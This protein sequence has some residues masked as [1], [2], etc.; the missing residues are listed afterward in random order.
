MSSVAK[1]N[2]TSQGLF[3]PPASV[4][5]LE[6]YP[7]I[8]GTI[9]AILQFWRIILPM[10]TLM[11]IT[12]CLNYYTNETASFVIHGLVGLCSFLCFVLMFGCISGHDVR[13]R[14]SGWQ[15]RLDNDL[16]YGSNDSLVTDEQS[17]RRSMDEQC[18]SSDKLVS[19]SSN[20][21]VTV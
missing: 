5:V 16:T 3:I 17:I 4:V 12:Q 19:V 13:L 11:V 8:A 7:Y 15:E 18:C 14:M 10:I 20:D 2:K 21:I 1:L 9:S 6:P